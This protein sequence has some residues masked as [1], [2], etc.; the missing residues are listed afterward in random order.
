MPFQS[1]GQFTPRTNIRCHKCG[2]PIG[3]AFPLK[4]ATR[5]EGI[6]AGNFCP[7]PMP[8]AQQAYEEVVKENPELVEE[9]KQETVFK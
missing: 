3:P 9:F 1:R 6:A 4:V 8:C 2:R 5:Q 7:V